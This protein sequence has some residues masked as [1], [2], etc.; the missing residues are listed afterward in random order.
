MRLC[1]RRTWS[2]LAPAV[3]LAALCALAWWT[4]RLPGHG[5]AAAIAIGIAALASAL[6]LRGR[7][8]GLGADW[9]IAVALALAA[10]LLASLP[11]IVEGRFGI[12]GTGL[13]PDMSQHLFAVDRLASGDSERLISQGYPLGPHSI[14]VALSALG[15]NTV[16]AF[17]GL[18]L[19]VAVAACLAPLSLLGRLG[20]WRRVTGALCVGFAYLVAAYLVQGAFKETMQALFVLAFALAIAEAAREWPQLDAGRRRLAA[21]PAAVLAI[22]SAYVYSFPGLLWLGG[23][24]GVWA[25][26]EALLAARRRGALA[27]GLEALRGAA[28]PVAIGVVVLILAIAPELGRMVDFASF[29]TFDPAGSGLGNLFNRLSPLEALGIW[30]SGD[31][32]RRARRRRRPG[33]R[34]LRRRRLR[35][36][37]RW[38]MD[39]RGG[40]GAASGRCPRRSSRRRCSGSTPWSPGPRTRRPRR[41]CSRRRWWR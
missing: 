3:G 33:D 39:S 14:V 37:R 29:E 34:L 2:H 9:R 10:A 16:Q 18:T 13:N 41:W 5:T 21:V 20:A 38:A 6:A 25:L 27:G 12:L 23:A 24:L 19:A 1:G 30:P 26:V 7:V 32:R 31:F 17:D 28:P 4:V 40:G 15:P 22:G 8:D 11:F 36:R 35:A